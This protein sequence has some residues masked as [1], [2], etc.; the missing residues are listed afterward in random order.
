MR[1]DLAII[2]ILLLPF[3]SSAAGQQRAVIDVHVHAGPSP[4]AM[5]AI[6][7]SLG[8]RFAIVS[9][10]QSDLQTWVA[11]DTG[12][13]HFG[14]VFPC[15]GGRAPITGAVCFTSGTEFP[16]ITWLRAELESR[17]IR[18]LGELLPQFMGISPND[19][20]MEPYW[21]LAE[22]FDVPV[23]LHMGPGP[24]AIGYD[25]SPIAHKSPNFRM[26]AGDPLLL[27]D[28]LL[29]HKRLRVYIMHAGWPR[30]ES[31]LA[32]LYAH[33]NVYV[34][35]GALQFE[36]I[37]SRAAYLSYLRSLVDAGFAQRIMFGSDFP[38]LQRL[39]ID[40]ILQAD[41]LTV[42]QKRDILCNNAVRFFRLRTN[43]CED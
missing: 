25:V 19:A 17:R 24:R 30:L 10:L 43:I 14:L 41:F 3:T 29:R 37:M 9:G 12:R 35:I 1:V 42:A 7:D 16:D 28:V 18:V 27:E 39:G 34:D 36:N 20:R 40:I 2:A 6:H 11:A 13:F 26:S 32:L 4:V 22:E 21:R 31:L 15:E 8:V 33:P 38:D 23:A 5:T